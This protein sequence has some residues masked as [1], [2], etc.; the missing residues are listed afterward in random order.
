MMMTGVALAAAIACGGGDSNNGSSDSN[1]AGAGGAPAGGGS[2]GTGGVSFQTASLERVS[3]TGGSREQ[4][5]GV[6]FGGPM[7]AEGDTVFW[8]DTSL[9]TIEKWSE[10]TGRVK[11]SGADPNDVVVAD[12]VVYWTNGFI[13]G[14]VGAVDADGTGR[15][16]ILCGLRNPGALFVDGSYLI[17]DADEGILRMDR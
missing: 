2:G 17:V 8:G 16:S 1:D 9:K 10:A 13:T 3:L 4:L 11:L 15:R 6:H 5:A 7:A 12:G 14:S